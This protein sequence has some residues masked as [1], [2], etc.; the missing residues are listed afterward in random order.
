MPVD[1]R[2]MECIHSVEYQIMITL[3]ILYSLLLISKSKVLVLK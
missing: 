3:Q 2:L 1:Q